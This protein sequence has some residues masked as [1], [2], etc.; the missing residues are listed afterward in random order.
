MSAGREP[1]LVCKVVRQTEMQVCVD[2]SLIDGDSGG[3]VLDTSPAKMLRSMRGPIVGAR[4]AYPDVLHVEV[5]NPHGERW[6]LATQDAE[7]SPIDP[8]RL[9]GR[10]IAD[11]A[12]DGA[13]GE[14]SFRFAEGSALAVR[15]GAANAAD[16]PPCWELL[17]PNGVVLEFGLGLRW[18]M[19]AAARRFDRSAISAALSVGSR[20]HERWILCGSHASTER[21]CWPPLRLAGYRFP[22]LGVCQWH[23]PRAEWTCRTDSSATAAAAAAYVPR[24]V[25]IDGT[26]ASYRVASGGWRSGPVRRLDSGQ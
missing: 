11:I 18:R 17:G 19:G 12:V 6:R 3:T 26:N 9:V 23:R 5:R 20:C 22:H 2:A 1:K 7:W 14:L 25:R 13:T 24:A 16:D 21:D 15:P 8:E 4:I 10:S